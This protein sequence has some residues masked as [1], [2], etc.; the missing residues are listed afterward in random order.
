M[1]DTRAATIIYQAQLRVG[2]LVD[3][4][5]TN[6]KLGRQL[7]VTWNRVDRIIQN[8]EAYEERAKLE[9]INQMNYVLEELIVLADI[10][11]FP[12][13][14]TILWTGPPAI[15][16][17]QQG[18]PG[19]S[20]TGATGATGATGLATDFQVAAITSDTTVDTF[21]LIAGTACRWD[22]VVTDSLGAQ[23]A[24][25]VIGTWKS[26]GTKD[27]FDVATPDI[28]GSTAGVEFDLQISGPNVNL[29]ALRTAGTWSVKGTRYFTP[30][31]G[32]GSGPVGDVLADGKYYIGN[33]SNQATA[34]T[35]SGAITS[36]N[37][38]VT[39]VSNNYIT[40][41]MVNSAA[42]IARTKIASGT[43]YRI[44]ANSAAGVMSENAALTASK[45]VVS[46]TNGQLAS[47]TTSATDILGIV[48]LAAFTTGS[49]PFVTSGVLTQDN[50]NFSWDNT[51]KKLFIGTGTGSVADTRIGKLKTIFSTADN[52]VFHIS[53]FH[54]AEQ[55]A[56]TTQSIQALEGY[57][58]I[59]HTSGTVALGI[60]TI[61]NIE[62]SGAAGTTTFA[63][64]VQ[65]GVVVSAAATVTAAAAF[66]GGLV[67]PGG[68]TITD[69]YGLYLENFPAGVTNK[70]FLYCLDTNA[71]SIIAGKIR[72]SG[73]PTSAAGLPSGSMWNN[74][75]V[76]NI[77]P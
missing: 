73:L 71:V 41:I 27:M 29:V 20:I 14:P 23:R 33:G 67:N 64:A 31:N 19:A 6:K 55:T 11:S 34:R 48:G 54:Q 45:A 8:L 25:Q 40:N 24:G 70:W 39:T 21:L 4:L 52:T 5:V 72:T 3:Y 42:A 59:S 35:L 47:S 38:G 9:D 62:I 77:V 44:L 10:A 7:E 51:N 2:T 36:T 66:Y 68:G 57:A 69:G 16:V 60:G 75:N 50:T 1:L 32:D 18:E 26:D 28:G 37:T 58:K 46:D 43:N 56:A 13:A 74:A 63:R 17:G 15:W 61:G 49:V 76:V 12:S 53:S 30:N 65:G 22:Y